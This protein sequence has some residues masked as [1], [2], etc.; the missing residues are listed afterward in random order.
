MFNEQDFERRF[1]IPCSLPERIDSALC[2]NYLFAHRQDATE[3]KGI[4]PNIRRTAALR[5]FA[6]GMSFD[7]TDELHKIRTIESRDSVLVFIRKTIAE[8]FSEYL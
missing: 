7:Q 1:S 8:C 3:K 2:G 5:I 6:Y 4:H